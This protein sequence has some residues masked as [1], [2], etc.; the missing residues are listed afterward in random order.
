[1]YIPV[2]HTN[3]RSIKNTLQVS[4]SGYV[5]AHTQRP[6]LRRSALKTAI[7]S[8]NSNAELPDSTT[9]SK[10]VGRLSVLNMFRADVKIPTVG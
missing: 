4:P 1:M 7:E 9:D 5:P 8:P 2:S 10:I 3:G 6:I